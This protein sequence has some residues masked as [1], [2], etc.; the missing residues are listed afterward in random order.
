MIRNEL[1]LLAVPVNAHQHL[2]GGRLH[3]VE[4][5]GQGVAP[6]EVPEV[7]PLGVR[8]VHL[9]SSLLHQ[10]QEHLHTH[11]HQAR[12]WSTHT[13]P[14]RALGLAHLLQGEGDGLV[15]GSRLG[16]SAP[17]QRHLE[18]VS[19]VVI[20]L[21]RG[22]C[23]HTHTQRKRRVALTLTYC[24]KTGAAMLISTTPNS[25]SLRKPAN[26]TRRS[27]SRSAIATASASDEGSLSSS[28]PA[29]PI[30][31]SST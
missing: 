10:S 16:L 27:F 13:T 19:K 8:V 25:T 3:L 9:T 21:Q 18:Q 31:S 1:R 30:T 26:W 20:V 7:C 12:H 28:S 17:R 5:E 11:T 14:G 2:P 29:P 22:R 4:A 24:A 6:G 15:P 23:I